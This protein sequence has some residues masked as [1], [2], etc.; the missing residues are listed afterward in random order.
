MRVVIFTS[1]RS[2]RAPRGFAVR[3][4]QV[5]LLGPR[6]PARESKLKRQKS[7]SRPRLEEVEGR[8]MMS[9]FQV[10]T[11]RDTVAVNLRTG[12][13][14][15]GHISLRSAIMAANAK[16]G[17]N[18]INLRKG[19]YTLSIAGTNEDASATGDLD[20]SSNLISKGSGS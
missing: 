8:V 17:S 19:R 2:T 5:N 3:K 15:T 11:T 10:N 12:K 9:T 18:T 14:S 16:G 6:I 7:R 13:D 20:I 1:R 4:L